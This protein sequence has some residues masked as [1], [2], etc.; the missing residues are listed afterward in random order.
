MLLQGYLF[1]ILSALGSAVLAVFYKLGFLMHVSMNDLLA[2]RFLGAA[3][4]LTVFAAITKK[5]QLSVIKSSFKDLLLQSAAYFLASLFYLMATRHLFAAVASML[6]YLYPAMVVLIMTFF[7]HEKLTVKRMLSLGLVF[8]GCLMVINIFSQSF[9][10]NWHGIGYGFVSAVMFAVYIVRG[11]KTSRE[12]GPIAIA[13]LVTTISS[14]LAIIILPPPAILAG[15]L[16]VPHFLIGLGSAFLCTVL[17]VTLYL[18][19][20]ARLGAS[21]ASITST[22]ELAF[23]IGFAWLFL[24]EKLLPIQLLGSAVIIL[25]IVVLQTEKEPA[26]NI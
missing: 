7:Y 20:L 15:Q 11:Q 24:N 10:I 9:Q 19:G 4:I 14:L 16:T 12:V 2:M 25:G 18:S 17:P 26:G 3:A 5:I 13:A 22:V 1:V 6:F 23:T 21:R 8:L